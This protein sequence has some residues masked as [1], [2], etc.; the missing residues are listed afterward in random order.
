MILRGV[1]D[2]GI[3]Q[4][5]DQNILF[6]NECGGGPAASIFRIPNNAIV[7]LKR[8]CIKKRV[9][10]VK[11]DASECDF[12]MAVLNPS[13]ARLFKVKAEQRFLLVF[14]SNTNIMTLIRKPVTR[15]T[16]RFFVDNG[17]TED[18]NIFIAGPFRDDFGIP[19]TRNTITLVR[20][21]VCKTLSILTS[22]IEV[23]N[24]SFR[25]TAK[26]AA[27]FQLINGRRYKLAYNQITNRLV[28]ERQ[29]T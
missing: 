29:V 14:N 12:H 6:I 25:L 27:K 22:D 7:I 10:V 18:D 8:G 3:A 9:R 28:I 5:Q 16:A 1:V 19:S 4:N 26:N 21:G 24:L 20:G 15:D 2:F 11:G 13:T 17:L 23:P